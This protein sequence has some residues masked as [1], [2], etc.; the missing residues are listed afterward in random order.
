MILTFCGHSDFIRND[1]YERLLLEYFNTKIGNSSAEFYLGGYGAFDSFAYECARKY[2]ADHP[3]VRLIYVTPYLSASYQ[4]G[5]LKYINDL[6]DE[7]LYPDLEN[8]P[9]KYAIIKRNQWMAEA[10]DIVVSYVKHGFG[11]AYKM[12]AYAMK[13]GKDIFNLAELL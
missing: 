12:Y 10:S 5:R 7:I 9:Q 3:F 2:K 8:V 1:E 6:Y 4:K 13:K 11:G